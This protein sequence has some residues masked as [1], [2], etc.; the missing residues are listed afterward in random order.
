M[1]RLITLTVYNLVGQSIKTSTL[2]FSDQK[3]EIDINDLDNG[4]YFYTLHDQNGSVESGKI[5]LLKP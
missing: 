3:A 5:V 2:S 1:K 4:V